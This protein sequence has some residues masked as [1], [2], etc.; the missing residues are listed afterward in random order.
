MRWLIFLSISILFFQSC[1]DKKS[2]DPEVIL[3][4]VEKWPV[5]WT[6]DGVQDLQSHPALEQ[7]IKKGVVFENAFTTS[8]ESEL[9]MQAL[10]SG[11]HTGHLLSN[12]FDKTRIE[13]FENALLSK[14]YKVLEYPNIAAW[15]NLE[16]TDPATNIINLRS[17]NLAQLN[18]EVANLL[19]SISQNTLIVF[20]ALSGA[21]AAYSESSLRV[22]LVFYTADD[23]IKM[24]VSKQAIYTADLFPTIA[25]FLNVPYSAN[26]LDGQSFY[27]N[28]KQPTTPLDDRILYWKSS[29][30]NG[31]EILRYNQWKMRR[32]N[33][34][35]EWHLFDM[36]TDPKETDNVS[37]YHPGKFEK[38]QEWIGKNK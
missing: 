23:K 10:K 32:E 17:N 6:E 36:I 1:S 27:K 13:G 35:V 7:L 22:P 37:A 26:T 24:G 30:K 29:D 14:A 21:G 25:D 28:I 3:L 33:P 2:N 12:D 4:L 18:G 31:P 8:P 34:D 5:E 9:A 20:T 19:T 16:K 11:M 38:F 15:S